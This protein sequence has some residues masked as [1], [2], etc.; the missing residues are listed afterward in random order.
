ML[1]N[2]TTEAKPSVSVDIHNSEIFIQLK[3]PVKLSFENQEPITK[4]IDYQTTLKVRLGLVYNFLHDLLSLDSQE[5]DFDIKHAYIKSQYYHKGFRLK[6]IED[7]C[8]IK[9]PKIMIGNAS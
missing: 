1:V 4:I 5:I 9:F 6:K 3:Y 2:I 7:N 8:T